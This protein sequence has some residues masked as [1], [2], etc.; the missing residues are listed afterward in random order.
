MA[1]Q[2]GQL[3]RIRFPIR[4]RPEKENPRLAGV[5]VGARTIQFS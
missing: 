4:F 3:F 1:A 5:S 2:Y